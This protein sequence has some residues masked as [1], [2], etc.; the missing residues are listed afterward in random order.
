MLF[1]VVF[2]LSIYF[3]L[4]F[5]RHYTLSVEGNTLP[6]KIEINMLQHMNINWIYIS[7]DGENDHGTSG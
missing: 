2:A 7:F 1:V 3:P 5:D 4:L 6:G